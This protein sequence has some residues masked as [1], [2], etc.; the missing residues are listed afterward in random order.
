[1]KIL[2]VAPHLPA[3]TIGVNT[4]NYHLLRALAREHQVSVVALGDARNPAIQ[5]D[6]RDSMASP[7]RCAWRPCPPATS[8]ELS[9]STCCE[10]SR[11]A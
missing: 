8:A 6:V 1:M 2:M 5:A 10:V 9:F 3:P 4:R 11:T 7:M